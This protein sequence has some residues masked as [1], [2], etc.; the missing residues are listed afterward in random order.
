MA[1][2]YTG[3]PFWTDTAWVVTA[4]SK[5]GQ[6]ASRQE[7]INAVNAWLDEHDMTYRWSGEQTHERNGVVTYRYDVKIVSGGKHRTF[8]KL[9]WS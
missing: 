1:Y 8:F 5:S 3:E 4:R 9:K 7:F 6:Y 2:L